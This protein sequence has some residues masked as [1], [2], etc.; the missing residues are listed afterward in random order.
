[1]DTTNKFVL[2]KHQSGGLWMLRRPHKKRPYISFR[3]WEQAVRYIN[4]QDYK[5]QIVKGGEP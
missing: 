1:M 3:T 5:A 2:Y 4:G